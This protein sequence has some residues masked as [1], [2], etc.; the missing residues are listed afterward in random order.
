MAFYPSEES[1]PGLWADCVH[2]RR[3]AS[4]GLCV[5]GGLYLSFVWL[6][7]EWSQSGVGDCIT[8]P[9]SC[10]C[11]LCHVRKHFGSIVFEVM[12]SV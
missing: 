10:V 2:L 8:G 9:T 5:G 7:C 1:L 12:D 3:L 11:K 4:F 6:A